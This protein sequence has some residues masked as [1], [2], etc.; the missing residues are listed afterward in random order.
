MPGAALAQAPQCNDYRSFT[1]PEC[2]TSQSDDI[3]Q[4]GIALKQT[5]DSESS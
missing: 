3:R 4:G 2:V 5:F 1:E